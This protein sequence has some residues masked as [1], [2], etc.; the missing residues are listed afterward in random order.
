[1][2]RAAL[3]VLCGLLAGVCMKLVLD[4]RAE[5][6]EASLWGELESY[7]SSDEDVRAAEEELRKNQEAFDRYLAE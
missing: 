5:K 7:S 6:R 3:V 2:K 4:Y 1:M